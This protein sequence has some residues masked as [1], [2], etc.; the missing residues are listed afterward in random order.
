VAVFA[1]LL[2]RI[3]CGGRRLRREIWSRERGAGNWKG[4]A[5]WSVRGGEDAGSIGGA[6][7]GHRSR[8][9]ALPPESRGATHS[10][11]AVGSVECFPPRSVRHECAPIRYAPDRLQPWLRAER[12]KSTPARNRVIHPGLVEENHRRAS[13]SRLIPACDRPPKY[14]DGWPS[15]FRLLTPGRRRSGGLQHRCDFESPANIA[16]TRRLRQSRANTRKVI[17]R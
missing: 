3:A 1:P 9:D 6:C 8:D 10:F 17:C 7:G 15:R 4:R 13:S 16:R 5:G 11:C 12:F 2:A 14:S